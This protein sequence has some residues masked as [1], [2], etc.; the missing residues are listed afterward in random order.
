MRLNFT[1][2][3]T[4]NTNNQYEKLRRCGDMLYRNG[5]LFVGLWSLL[6]IVGKARGAGIFGKLNK[7]KQTKEYKRATMRRGLPL[8]GH[9]ILP[10]CWP[11]VTLGVSS[12][13][14]SA[15]LR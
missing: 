6:Y 7:I 2:L 9:C 4:H 12:E 10:S 5:L 8:K 14:A 1:V 3:E 11:A 13:L 15:V